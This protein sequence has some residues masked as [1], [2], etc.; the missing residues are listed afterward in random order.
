MKLFKKLIFAAAFFGMLFIGASAEE[1]VKHPTGGMLFPK[2]IPIEISSEQ[3]PQNSI[4]LFSNQSFEDYLIEQCM[5]HVKTI[6]IYAYNIP[7]DEI[8]EIY[9]SFATRHPEL[10]IRTKYTQYY[11]KNVPDTTAFIE[12]AYIFETAEQDNTARD[13]MQEKINEYVELVSQFESPLEKL[14]AV[15]DKM[16]E[17]YKYDYSATSDDILPFHAYGIF[18]NNTAVC[19]GYAQAYYM[20]LRELGIEAN[21]CRSDSINHLWNYV[22]LDGKWYHVDVTWDDPNKTDNISAAYHSNFLLSDDKRFQNIKN[23]FSDAEHDWIA[24]L[25]AL[26]DCGNDFE[27]TYL[28]NI[29]GLIVLTYDGEYFNAM[30]TYSGGQTVTFRSKSLKAGI[31]AVSAPIPQ[32]D[33]CMLYYYVLSDYNGKLTPTVV[34][35]SNGQ[36]SSFNMQNA[37]NLSKYSSHGISVIFD[38]SADSTDI[39][40]WDMNTLTPACEK[41]SI[42]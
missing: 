26:P 42:D 2:A 41:I 9:F 15:H 12:P 13:F 29:S 36:Y 22:K 24:Y 11:Y 33:G 25:D 7:V 38:T 27:S 4:R 17:N 40:I 16:V 10:L 21:F 34:T 19:Q 5:N 6:D 30:H 14:L 35:S 3:A 8:G 20:I 1:I 32:T 31:I 39:F 28:F 37:L 18:K 23:S